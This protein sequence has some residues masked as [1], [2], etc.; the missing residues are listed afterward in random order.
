[1]SQANA[2]W[3][4]EIVA[5]SRIPQ[6]EWHHRHATGSPSLVQFSVDSEKKLVTVRFGQE[7][8]AAD[9]EDYAACLQEHPLFDPAFSEIAD[10][11]SVEQLDLQADEFL[12]LADEVDPFSYDAKRAFVVG[13][14]TQAHAVR[15]HK[16]LRLQ[17]NFQIFS[18]LEEAQRWI[19]SSI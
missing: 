11:S 4:N 16:H 15:M 2:P 12:R 9:I 7:V 19:A 3:R 18:S 8:T 1:M 5:I 10:L 13:N 14:S 17:R 6:K